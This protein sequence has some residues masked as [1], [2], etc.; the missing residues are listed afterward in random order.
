[1]TEPYPYVS[2]WRATLVF[3]FQCAA[4]SLLLLLTLGVVPFKCCNR[5][6]C[7]DVSHGSPFDSK[8]FVF[9]SLCMLSCRFFIGSQVTLLLFA[10][11]MSL[12]CTLRTSDLFHI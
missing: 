9:D 10:F 2:Q 1:M 4:R 3:L 5:F 7:D 6:A 8:L 11:C 12:H